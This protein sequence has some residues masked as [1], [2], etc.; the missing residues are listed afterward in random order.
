LP[1]FLQYSFNPEEEE[2]GS[3][4]EEEGEEER[5]T[6]ARRQ[7]HSSAAELRNILKEPFHEFFSTLFVVFFKTTF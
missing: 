2:G 7:R 5:Q 6:A 3:G 1:K 4:S